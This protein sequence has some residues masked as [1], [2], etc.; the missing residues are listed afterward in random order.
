MELA[1]QQVIRAPRQ[2]V[3]QA[4]NDPDVLSRCIPG[5]ESVERVS[6]HETHARMA[7]KVGPV[8]ARFAGKILLS[9]VIAP[10][11]CTLNFEGSGGA[12][13]FARG[14]SMVELAEEADGTRVSYTVDASVGGKLGQVG[15]RLIDASARKLAD[16][17]FAA[18]D[19]ALSEGAP[20]VGAAAA[21]A[22]PP[23]AGDAAAPPPPAAVAPPPARSSVPSPGGIAGELHRAFWFAFGAAVALLFCRYLG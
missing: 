22:P 20:A 9:E 11:R 15:G 10:S 2:K 16:E 13:G 8:R 3:W 5:C 21:A 18:F 23:A 4:L 6:E 1:G 7:L 17:F 12:A 14:R 19:E